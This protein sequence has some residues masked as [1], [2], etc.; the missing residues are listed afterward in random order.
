MNNQKNYDDLLLNEEEL[1]KRFMEKGSTRTEAGSENTDKF[2]EEYYEQANDALQAD[3]DTKDE[4]SDEIRS[5]KDFLPDMNPLF[6]PEAKSLSTPRKMGLFFT[7]IAQKDNARKLACIVIPGFLILFLL[8]NIFTPSQKVS[9][10]ENRTLAAFP[11]ISIER[12][13]DGKFMK[14][15]EM[16]NK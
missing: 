6:S 3:Y 8:L 7:L 5:V 2:Y 15:F 9:E 11:E 4:V 14:D 13:L 10:K 1:F 12:I 16:R